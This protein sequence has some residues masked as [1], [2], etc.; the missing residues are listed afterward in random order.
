VDRALG[1]AAMWFSGTE[2][3][4]E[5]LAFEAAELWVGGLLSGVDVGFDFGAPTSSR[6]MPGATDIHEVR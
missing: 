5:W 3:I 4:C 1:Q 2:L 6:G